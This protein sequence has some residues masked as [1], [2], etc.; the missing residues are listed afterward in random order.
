[1]IY[2]INKIIFSVHATNLITFYQLTKTRNEVKNQLT[3]RN[4]LKLSVIPLQ[5]WVYIYSVSERL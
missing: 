2:A 3:M 1:L 4:K 5:M